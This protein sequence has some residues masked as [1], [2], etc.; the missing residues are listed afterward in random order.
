[1]EAAKRSEER[2]LPKVGHLDRFHFMEDINFPANFEGFFRHYCMQNRTC[3]NN[4]RLFYFV[5]LKSTIF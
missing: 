3:C 2:L 4:H 5:C 1:M